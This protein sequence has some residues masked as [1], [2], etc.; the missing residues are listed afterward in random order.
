MD[1]NLFI[2]KFELAFGSYELPVAIW[3]SESP[4]GTHEK[5]KGCFIKYLK[6]AREGGVVSVN[7]DSI[8]CPG[9]KI[10]TGF[11]EMPEFIPGYVS[12]KEHY[13]ETP[14]MVVD[15]IDALRM[16]DQ[17]ARYLNFA[18]LDQVD[19][20][21]DVE[22]LLFFATPD[23]LTGL[24][25][26]ALYDTKEPY[27]VSV[28]FGSGCSS[29]IAKTIVENQNGGDEVFIGFLDPSVRPHVEV[30]I[31]SFAVP[32]SRFKKMYHTFD[33]SCLK[34]THAWNKVKARITNEV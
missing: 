32:M 27:S 25:S 1:K 29:I 26:W 2:E 9:G 33:D 24:V 18:S 14:E 15:F 17:S 10:Y 11:S 22:G 4:Y 7:V 23:V 34:G 16:P 28:P 30:N 31:L 19:S 5:T 20:F 6:P 21:D 13:K 8:S 12:Q 3:Y